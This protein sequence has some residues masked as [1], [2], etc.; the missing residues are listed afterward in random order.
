MLYTV[1]PLL[2]LLMSAAGMKSH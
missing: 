1:V 2:H